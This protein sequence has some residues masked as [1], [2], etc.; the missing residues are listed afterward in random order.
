MIIEELCAIRHVYYALRA[1]I[2]L[3]YWYIYHYH[4]CM[5]VCVYIY[6]L[7]N[8]TSSLQLFY[9]ALSIST[10]LGFA[11][12]LTRFIHYFLSVKKYFHFPRSLVIHFIRVLYSI[13]CHFVMMKK[14]HLVPLFEYWTFIIS[15]S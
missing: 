1:I 8:V 15:L 2:Y 14:H 4:I 3:L 13:A 6:I 11:S 7:M 5:C 9:F 10:V 12:D